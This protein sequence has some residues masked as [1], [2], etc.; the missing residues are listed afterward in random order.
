MWKTDLCRY[1]FVENSDTQKPPWSQ[2]RR[3]RRK[4]RKV[5]QWQL[6]SR[7]IESQTEYFRRTKGGSFFHGR[8][9]RDVTKSVRAPWKTLV[10][11]GRG[12]QIR[13]IAVTLANVLRRQSESIITF[14]SAGRSRAFTCVGGEWEVEEEGECAPR[15]WFAN[16]SRRPTTGCYENRRAPAAFP[17]S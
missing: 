10:L 4:K 6:G 3:R 13:H 8:D 11:I 7:V 16:Q 9:R 5:V 12:G 1:C 14:A 15:S 2:I 17:I